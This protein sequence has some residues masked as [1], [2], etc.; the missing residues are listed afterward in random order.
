[1]TDKTNEIIRSLEHIAGCLW[2]ISCT[3]ENDRVHDVLLDICELLSVDIAK[4]EEG[5]MGA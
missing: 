2:G 4:L 3:V 1:M 5:G